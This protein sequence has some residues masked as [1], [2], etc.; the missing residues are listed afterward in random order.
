MYKL[1]SSYVIAVGLTILALFYI[2]RDV[3]HVHSVGNLVN[4]FLVI[5]AVISYVWAGLQLQ[6][7]IDRK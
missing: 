3:Y 7:F 1:Y 5:V 4:T 2:V 6:S